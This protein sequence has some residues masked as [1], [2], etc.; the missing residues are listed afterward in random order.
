[1][2]GEFDCTRVSPYVSAF[3]FVYLLAVAALLYWVSGGDEVHA[4]ASI[5]CAVIA[6]AC[7]GFCL[8]DTCCDVPPIAADDVEKLLPNAD[9]VS[10]KNN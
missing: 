2:C 5:V 4:N 7:G 10:G 6:F 8:Y 9:G 1:M 3:A